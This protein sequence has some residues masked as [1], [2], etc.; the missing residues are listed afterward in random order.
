M[1]TSVNAFEQHG[2][3]LFAHHLD[4]RVE[5]YAEVIHQSFRKTVYPVPT[6]RD[7]GATSL[8]SRYHF[9]TWDVFGVLLVVKD[10]GKGY[11]MRGV[12]SDNPKPKFFDGVTIAQHGGEKN[13]EKHRFHANLL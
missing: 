2:V 7:V 4:A 6:R 11:H 10:F 13:T 8:E 3:D 5:L 12:Q 9:S 1:R